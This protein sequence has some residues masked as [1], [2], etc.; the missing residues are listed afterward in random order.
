MYIVSISASKTLLRSFK[1]LNISL[2]TKDPRACISC[3]TITGHISFKCFGETVKFWRGRFL[4][5][6]CVNK[7]KFVYG[8]AAQGISAKTDEMIVVKS[9][10]LGSLF[11]QAVHPP[12]CSPFAWEK[13]RQWSSGGGSNEA[14]LNVRIDLQGPWG[15]WKTDNA[16]RSALKMV[17]C[18]CYYNYD[19]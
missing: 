18:Y 4:Y 2:W 19:L 6:S 1:R 3:W 16:Q 9:N 17:R 14:R 8:R 7:G 13:V 5:L 12:G 15:R 10:H 11:V